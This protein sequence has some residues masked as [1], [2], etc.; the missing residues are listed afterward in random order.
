MGAGWGTWKPVVLRVRLEIGFYSLFVLPRG[1]DV[2]QV[3]TNVSWEGEVS[4]WAVVTFWD[5]LQSV[6]QVPFSVITLTAVRD[7]DKVCSVTAS[8]RQGAMKGPTASRLTTSGVIEGIMVVGR[9]YLHQR[10]L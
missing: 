9:F 5:L 2:S 8:C 10:H 1:G 4:L 6:F 3:Q 7:R